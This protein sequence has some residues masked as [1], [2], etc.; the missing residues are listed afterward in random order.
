L[1]SSQF[2][3]VEWWRK[4]ILTGRSGGEMLQ[5][6]HGVVAGTAVVPAGGEVVGFVFTGSEGA[7]VR[8]RAVLHSTR[9]IR[10]TKILFR[11][12]TFVF[13]SVAFLVFW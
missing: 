1:S 12:I 9:I 7:V 11:S 13:F 4:M 6:W 8:Q 10:I 2:V 3:P 5:D